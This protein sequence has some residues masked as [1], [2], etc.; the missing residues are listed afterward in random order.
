[1]K[2]TYLFLYALIICIICLPISISAQAEQEK[3]KQ[4]ENG[5]STYHKI[6][7]EPTWTIEER[8]AHY[9][10]PGMS[11]AVIHNHKLAWAK[12]YGYVDK[13]KSA[14]VTDKTLFQAASISKPVSAY[15][16]L[17]L[18]EAGQL[19]LNANVNQYLKSWQIP[20]NEFTKDEKVTLER[21]VSHKAGLT[22]HGFLGYSTDLEVPS[23]IQLLDGQKPANSAAIRVDKVPGGEMRYSG[24]GYCVMQQMMI[25]VTGKTYPAIIKDNV[26]DPIG[27]TQSTF[28]QP[29]PADMLKLAAT[30]Y[31]P[32]GSMVKGKRHTYPEMAAAGL[33]TNAAELAKFVID[34]QQ[35][36]GAKSEQVL[37]T[38]MA[39]KMVTP[40]EGDFIGLGIFLRDGRFGHGGWNEGFSS[41]MTGH[42]KNGYGVVVMLNANQ[43]DL[44]N[45]VRD[46]VSRVYEWDNGAPTHDKL[47]FTQAEIDRISETYNYSFDDQ[48]TVYGEGDKVFLKYLVGSPQEL[49]K[50]ADNTY[51]RRERRSVIQFSND[52]S[53]DEPSL[54]F[55]PETEN[56][57]LEYKNVKLNG[58]EKLAIEYLLNGQFEKALSMYQ[59]K[60]NE[61]PDFRHTQEQYINSLGYQYL[62]NDNID[63]ALEIFKL[64][65]AL[66]PEAF[67]VYDSLAEV[68]MMKEQKKLAIKHYKKSLDLNPKN[69]NAVRMLAKLEK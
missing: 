24:G 42:I 44:I 31:V 36:L 6:K 17:R 25:D 20:D 48:I 45:E 47:A 58:G 41:D 28:A 14:P 68:Y 49:I 16:A 29:L 61:D 46:A 9:G 55:L 18:V 1:M 33:W 10:V 53:N 30:G 12:T 50:V 37:S 11:V 69:D 7:G 63:A 23:L 8:M 22:V 26:L 56:G 65:V 39:H 5:L 54:V 3:I 64:N 60:K 32:N 43:P 52:P 59:A 13:E 34:L 62:G 27:M 67:N 2:K 21:L 57:N 19:D 40:V 38:K 51:V 4:V 35:T 66:Y 15:A